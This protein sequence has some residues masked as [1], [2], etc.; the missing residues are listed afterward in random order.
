MVRLLVPLARGRQ[1]RVALEP[2]GTYGDALRQACQDAGLSVLR[3]SPKAAHDYAEVFDGVPSQHDGKDAG[4]VAELAAHGKG[5]PWDY[6][7]SSAFA[8]EL[9]YWVERL[10]CQQR[11]CSRCSWPSTAASP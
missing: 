6:Q 8:A 1:L 7:P 11:D 9:A 3:V 10:Q 2:S 4:V 5:W